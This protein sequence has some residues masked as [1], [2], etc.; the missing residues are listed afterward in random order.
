M[1]VSANDLITRSMRAL[2]ALGGGEVPS[3][4]EANDG[5][6]ALNAMLD[7]WSN[8][9]LTAYAVLENSFVLSPGT[10]SYTIGSGGVINV[11]RP[12][13][14][15][16]AYVQDSSGNNFIMQILPRDK[17]NEI[18]DRSTNITSQLPDTMFYDPQF[19]L[20]VI[21]IFPTPLLGYTVFFD[22]LL[23]QTTFASLTTNL[24]MPPGYERAGS[25]NVGQLAMESL[26][27][28]KRTNI[29]EN[30]ADYDPS[31]VSRSYYTYNIYRDV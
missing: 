15:T 16:Q 9:N 19:P 21:N 2:Q 22:S 3:A 8:E 5:L 12:L 28:I 18:G 4:S 7:S 6:T 1:A 11:T 29:R 24:A 17:W 14:I 25:K 30:I 10:N 26:G 27:N 23:Q 31:I 13:S 20:G